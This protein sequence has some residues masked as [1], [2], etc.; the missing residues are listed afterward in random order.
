MAVTKRKPLGLAW[1]ILIGLI[2]GITVGGIFYGNPHVAEW[3][4]PIGDIFIR[5]MKMIVVPIVFTTIVLG[6]SSVGS[7]KS[8]GRLGAKTLGYFTIVTMI[9]IFTGLFAANLVEPGAGI[10]MATL[11]K[12]D[13]STYVATEETTKDQGLVEKIVSIVPTNILDAMVRGDML[14]IIFFSVL[15]GL[16]V[17]FAGEK[18][19]PVV[20]FFEGVAAAMFNLVNIVMKFAPIGVFA[21]IGVTVSTFGIESLGSLF[22]L[23]GTLYVTA[24]LFM[25]IVF[26]S[27]MKWV[28]IRVSDFVRVFKDELLLTY[29]TASSETVLPRVMEKLEKMGVPKSIV[30]FVVPTGY[31]F[32]LDGSAL[33]QA[34][35]ALFIAQM[36]N[37]DLSIGTQ[38]T[39]VFV[40]MLTSKGMAAVPG[41]SFVVLL[42]TLG[43]VGIPA[44][45]LA[46]IAG[47]DRIM[48]MMRSVVNVTGNTL[49]SLVIA[50]WEGVL[51][52]DQLDEFMSTEG[53]QDQIKSA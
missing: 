25:V 27:I 20:R 28:G 12:T 18:G 17:G 4:K 40:L 19:L 30:S 22:K 3:L 52:S 29:S 45:G 11:E 2:L 1:Q 6:V 34:L 51:D 43:T 23:I 44:E 53:K 35:A 49:A 50:K 5:M 9:A 7:P 15:F 21:L 37:I 36:Y 31:S 8:L 42:A 47:I 16:G 48:D 13:I 24:L 10:N 39:L 26:G 32:N 41:V 46:F 33:Y 38:L 14:A